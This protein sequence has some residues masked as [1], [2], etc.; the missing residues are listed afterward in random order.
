MSQQSLVNL[1]KQANFLEQTLIESG[2]ELTP[3]LEEIL[4]NID[5]N[6]PEKVD[7]YY[8]VLERFELAEKYWKDKATAFSNISS[9]CKKLQVRLKENL[10]Y[11]AKESGG[12]EITGKEYRFK[13]Q[14]SPKSLV[15]NEDKLASKWY[16]EE[17]VLTPDKPRIKEA[18]EA[19]EKIEGAYFEQGTQL[20][21]YFNN[22]IRREKNGKT[23]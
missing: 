8:S 17:V 18:L 11:A 20:R 13:V 16:I 2:G 14:K 23:K 9:A 12:D 6:L 3:E 4:N 5:I 10:K 19:K 7:G 21:K 1:V 15:I 22:P